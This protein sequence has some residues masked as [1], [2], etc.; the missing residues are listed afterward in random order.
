MPCTLISDTMVLSLKSMMKLTHSFHFSARAKVMQLSYLSTM[1]KKKQSHKATL[2]CPLVY[3]LSQSPG[4][5]GF[6]SNWEKISLAKMNFIHR[7]IGFTR[8]DSTWILKGPRVRRQLVYSNGCKR[9]G[10]GEWVPPSGCTVGLHRPGPK[11][12]RT[13][14]RNHAIHSVKGC[15]ETH[16]E[17]LKD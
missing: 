8:H 15:I 17:Q 5:T 16:Q 1:A 2:I 14:Q 6:D 12:T 9:A 13:V 10:S 4:V 7:L 11:K 3:L